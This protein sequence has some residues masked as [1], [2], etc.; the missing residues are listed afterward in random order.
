MTRSSYFAGAALDGLRRVRAD[1]PRP[2]LHLPHVRAWT[3]GEV[4]AL[5]MA[6]AVA[7]WVIALVLA[8]LLL[9]SALES[10]LPRSDFRALYA[11]GK[12]AETSVFARVYELSEQDR[13]QRAFF[14]TD[15]EELPGPL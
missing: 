11:A 1:I 12:I 13:V 5:T 9:P 10:Y 14:D 15:D 6:G 4:R 3:G 7:A 8:W 2:M